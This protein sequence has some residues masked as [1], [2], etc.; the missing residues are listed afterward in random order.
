MLTTT[1]FR[2]LLARSPRPFRFT[3]RPPRRLDLDV[4]NLGVYVHIPF[5]TTLCAFCPYFKVRYD[6]ALAAAYAE[7]LLR[8][9]A[10]VGEL[11]DEPRE[12]VSIYFGGGT[13]TLMAD[14][15]PKIMEALG[16]H[17]LLRGNVGLEVHPRDI[18]DDL[19]GKLKDAGIDMVSIGIQSFGNESLRAL[20][21]APIDA[22]QR[23]R[24]MT[25]AGFA[26]VDVD[27]IFGIPGQR[28]EDLKED[29]RI[30][31]A[32]GATQISTYPFIDFSYAR[33]V[34]K[35]QD[36]AGKRRL[37]DAL[38]E[39]SAETGYE[40]TSVWTFARKGTP[41]YSSI[42]R[43]N[44]VGF[45]P[46]ASTLLARLFKINTFSVPEYI[47]SIHTRGS[48][49]ALTLRFDER[50]RAVY[51]LFWSAYNLFF[52]EG[53][54]RKLFGR[55]LASMFGA[56]LRMSGMLDLTERV[57]GGH[58]LTTRGAYVFHL[59]EQ[60]YTHQYIDKTWRVSQETPWPR[61][62]TLY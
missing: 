27:L 57:E 37:L 18:D 59:L 25:G 62:I 56:E 30:A 46:S 14:D 10:L 11:L 44:Y 15:L 5:C 32:N 51:W 12:I 13:P 49:T 60:H 58:R 28:V 3:D 42:T 43:D 16:R 9:I 4:P 8:E 6:P 1:L 34:R 23:L 61:Q 7:A 21:R 19:P 29:F 31:A 53:D 33:N 48:A 54:F 24:T 38:V 52:S 50:E 45:G 17:F 22:V 35:P 2:L 36:R 55:T 40:R 26:A 20:G 41:K 39:A 47:T